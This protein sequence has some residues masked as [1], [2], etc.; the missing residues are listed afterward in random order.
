MISTDQITNATNAT[1][2][3]R[4]SLP[5]NT[6]DKEAFLKLLTAQLKNQ[7]PLNPTDQKDFIQQVATFSNLEQQISTNQN[8]AK[9]LQ[10]QAVSQAASLIGQQ[11]TGLVDGNVVEGKVR[12]VIFVNGEPVMA[13]DNGGELPQSALISVGQHDTPPADPGSGDGSGT[14]PPSDG[15][16]GGDTPPPNSAT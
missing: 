6:L 9:M 12:E 3:G 7:D 13:L 2:G 8:M 15:S 10:F 5:N 1:N 14:P 11:V 16:G 4:T